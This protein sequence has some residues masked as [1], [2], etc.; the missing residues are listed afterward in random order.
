MHVRQANVSDVE[1]LAELNHQLI[2]DE[3]HRNN[4]SV[5]ELQSRMQSWLTGEYEAYLFSLAEATVGYTLFRRESEY[6]YLRQFFIVAD[7]RRRGLGRAAFEW[8]REHRW[9]SGSRLRLEVLIDN[10]R[11]L[12][13]WRA[14]GFRDYCLTLERDG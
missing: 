10:E 6:V 4:M 2:R 13:F 8:M 5:S 7:Y 9:R 12:D 14:M 3:G 1:L 11:A